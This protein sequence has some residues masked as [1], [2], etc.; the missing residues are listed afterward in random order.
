MRSF[1]IFLLATASAFAQQPPRANPVD[2][3]LRS[4]PGRDWFQHGRNVY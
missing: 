2:P 4:D 1:A 3:A